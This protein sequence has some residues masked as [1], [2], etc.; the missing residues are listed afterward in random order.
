MVD[1]PLGK[2]VG[3]TKVAENSGDSLLDPVMLAVSGHPQHCI[4]QAYMDGSAVCVVNVLG[5]VFLEDLRQEDIAPGI[6][7]FRFDS[8]RLPI[9]VSETHP[10]LG[11]K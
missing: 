9:N 4:P 7:C 3:L 5:R 2:D 8:F 10:P 11:L 1:A 6:C